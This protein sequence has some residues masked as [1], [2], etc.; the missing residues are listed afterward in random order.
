MPLD[1]DDLISTLDLDQKRATPMRQPRPKSSARHR[2]RGQQVLLGI[3]GVSM[4]LLGLLLSLVMWPT[5]TVTTRPTTPKADSPGTAVKPAPRR[6][7]VTLHG[8]S[9]QQIAVAGAALRGEAFEQ[10]PGPVVVS[11]KCRRNGRL[12]DVIRT[13]N[14]PEVD[15]AQLELSCP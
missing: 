6:V 5:P 15:A 7:R 8:P 10:A 14:V 11:W 9:A 1:P 4:L 13:F 2:S 3:I 12:V